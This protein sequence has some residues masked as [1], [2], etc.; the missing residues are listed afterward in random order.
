LATAL[1]FAKVDP[2]AFACWDRE[3]RGA[4]QIRGFTLVPERL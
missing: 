4:A 2:I 3:L 1:A